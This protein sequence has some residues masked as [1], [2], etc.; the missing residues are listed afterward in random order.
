MLFLVAYGRHR[1]ALQSID[2]EIDKELSSQH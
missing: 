2:Q 1:E